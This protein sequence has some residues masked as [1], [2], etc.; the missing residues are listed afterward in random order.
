MVVQ[1]LAV[2]PSETEKGL[3]KKELYYIYFIESLK[4]SHI[5]VGFSFLLIKKK[6]LLKS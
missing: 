5:S 2:Q 3:I 4:N 1:L 6:I